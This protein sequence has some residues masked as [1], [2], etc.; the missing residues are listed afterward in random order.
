MQHF[1]RPFF[2]QWYPRLCSTPFVQLPSLAPRG[3]RHFVCPGCDTLQPSSP[4]VLHL[5]L[6]FWI[7]D[8]QSIHRCHRMFGALPDPSLTFLLC[9]VNIVTRVI[10]R[11][12]LTFGGDSALDI[13][14]FLFTSFIL[15]SIPRL[16]L[17][18][19]MHNM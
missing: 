15:L 1:T 4:M 16:S 7:G 9:V 6:A 2:S 18:V 3:T 13:V 11:S 12:Q 10:Y 17:N 8:R 5:W 14:R 19:C